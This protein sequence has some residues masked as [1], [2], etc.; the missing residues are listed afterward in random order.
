MPFINSKVT[1]KISPEKEERIKQ[2]LGQAIGIIPGKS[3][4]WL[5]V[6]FEDEYTLYFKGNKCEKAAF[7]EVK[8][9]GSSDSFSHA[10]AVFD[11]MTAEI[12]KIYEEELGIPAASIY[13]AYQ[14]IEDWGW[15]GRNL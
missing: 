5:M 7:V 2:R 9:Y 12:C 13:I 11:N 3:E 15:N 14:M 4:S 10:G 6:G 1:V 8:V